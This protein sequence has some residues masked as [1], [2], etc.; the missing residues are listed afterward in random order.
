MFC[1]DCGTQVQPGQSFC[2]ACGKALSGYRVEQPGRLGRHIHLLGIFWIAYSAFSLVGGV[3]VMIV[4]HALF[5]P[6]ARLGAGAPEFLYPLLSSVGIFLLVK[7]IAGIGA[8]YGLLQHEA[9]A[10]VVALVLGFFDLLHV[11]LGTIL[12]IY[13]IW[14]LLSPGADKEYRSLPQAA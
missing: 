1:Q 13:T 3:A 12:G 6:S 4:A 2:G 14:A 10:R 9:W 7:A 11:P 8:G 5:R